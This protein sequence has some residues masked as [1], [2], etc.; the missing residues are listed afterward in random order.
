MSSGGSA[1]RAR[2]EEQCAQE[3]L[4]IAS[5]ELQK[6]LGRRYCGEA[7]LLPLLLEC[8]LISRVNAFDVQIR[9]GH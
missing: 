3:Q 5:A 8:S 6:Q 1:K 7:E 4:Y 2:V 9:P